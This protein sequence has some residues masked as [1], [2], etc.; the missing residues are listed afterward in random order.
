MPPAAPNQAKTTTE[1][2]E[3]GE[4]KTLRMAEVLE[5]ENGRSVSRGSPTIR[6]GRRRRRRDRRMQR[7]EKGGEKKR[8]S[9]PWPGLYSQRRWRE[10]ELSGSDN[11]QYNVVSL[12]SH[13]S[14]CTLHFLQ[15]SP[16]SIIS[17]TSYVPQPLLEFRWVQFFFLMPK[18]IF[19]IN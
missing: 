11:S 3:T 16:I 10:R 17:T 5:G 4:A 7:G 9:G 19:F 1:S 6:P 2:S 18:P 12:H 15:F 13:I 14:P 8:A